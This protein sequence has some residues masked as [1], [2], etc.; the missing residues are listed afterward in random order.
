M[1]TEQVIGLT[2]TAAGDDF[3]APELR[4]ARS[5]SHGHQQT[6]ELRRVLFISY[7]FPPVGGAG[8]Q[9]TTKFVKYLHDFGWSASV[10]TVANPSVPLYDR[11]LLAD[12]PKH[13]LIRKA[14]TWEPSYSL[15]SVIAAGSCNSERALGAVGGLV[16]RLGRAVVS[17]V[18]QPDPQALWIGPA[19]REGRRLLR[20]TPHAA[21]VASAPPF[22]TFLVG[23]ALSREFHIPL[24]LDYRDEWN[25]SNAYLENRRPGW[26]ARMIQQRMQNRAVRSASALIA[27]TRAS[28]RAL[29]ETRARAGA[30]AAVHW[31]YNGFDPADFST[32]HAPTKTDRS[33]YR[34]VYVG[35]LWNL[36]NV[37]PLVRAVERL[38]ERSPGLAERLE[39]VF[40]GRRIASQ[41]ELLDRLQRLPCRV[42]EHPYT[43]HAQALDLLRSADGLCLLLAD[44]PG[45]ERVVPAKLFE[46]MAARR[47]IL[48]IAPPGE[49]WELLEDHPSAHRFRPNEADALAAFLERALQGQESGESLHDWSGERFS[50]RYQ[51]GQLADILD[52]CTPA[53]RNDA[54]TPDPVRRTTET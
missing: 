22:S 36:T 7:I 46:Y 42:V 8:V 40:A 35:T 34:L 37:E 32:I 17:N 44:V 45:A 48:A 3:T 25:L 24:V 9:R 26:L 2:A 49:V 47:P 50:R 52:A 11:S 43:D 18:L 27:T 4:A 29:A 14:R 21:I 12:I 54:W 51:T 23:T 53:E 28:A 10:L 16:K 19:I 1:L 38:S 15:K 39:L 30:M 6:L 41:Q 5:D 13:T 33:C 20:G 31:I